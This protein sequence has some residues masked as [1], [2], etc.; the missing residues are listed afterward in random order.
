MSIAFLN[1]ALASSIFPT[2]NK[3]VPRFR[4]IASLVLQ[5]LM[6]RPNQPIAS[7]CKFLREYVTPIKLNRSLFTGFI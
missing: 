4:K 3:D 6:P 5:M 7:S 1:A 2:P